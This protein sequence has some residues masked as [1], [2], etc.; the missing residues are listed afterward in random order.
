MMDLTKAPLAIQE[1]ADWLAHRGQN[2]TAQSFDSPKNQLLISHPAK[3][4]IQVLADRGQWFVEL[5]PPGSGEFFDT[6]V[7][8]SCFQS[9]DVDVDPGPL[10][11]QVA[12]IVGY[13]LGDIDGQCTLDCL[14]STRKRRADA[15]IGFKERHPCCRCQ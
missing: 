8:R 1:L 3:G 10:A 14:L 6:S 2:L 11:D 7:W 12:W 9:A 15:R 13:I 5:S 4:S